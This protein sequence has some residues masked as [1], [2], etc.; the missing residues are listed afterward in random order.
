MFTYDLNGCNESPAF[1][2][3]TIFWLFHIFLLNGPHNRCY[4][5]ICFFKSKE[6][7]FVRFS[8]PRCPLDD[9]QSATD[10]FGAKKAQVNF[11]NLVAVTSTFTAAVLQTLPPP[12]RAAAYCSRGWLLHSRNRRHF[13]SSESAKLFRPKSVLWATSVRCTA[14]TGANAR[15]LRST[16]YTLTCLLYFEVRQPAAAVLNSALCVHGDAVFSSAASKQQLMS[17]TG[18]ENTNWAKVS[19]AMQLRLLC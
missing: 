6:K 3:F 14:S 15:L 9:D 4:I 19:V 18:W 1:L 16:P 5:L 12:R 8:T 13:F 11:W 17:Q 10:G 7:I 2:H